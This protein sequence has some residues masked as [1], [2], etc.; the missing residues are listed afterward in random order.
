MNNSLNGSTALLQFRFRTARHKKR[1]QYEDFDKQLLA[2]RRE[3]NILYKQQRN[4]GWIE[5]H[6]PVIR[7]WKRYFVLRDNVA[8]SKQAAFFESILSK[9]NTTQ[10]SHRKDFKV[11]KRK[12]GKKVD[13]AKAQHLLQ[14]E[15]LSFSRMKFT[16]AEKQYFEE[17]TV[18]DNWTSKP[19]KVFA[20]TE[21]GCFVLRVRP[22]IITKTR[23]R[24]EVIESRVQQIRNYLFNNVLRGRLDYL[25]DGHSYSWH[26]EKLKEKNP[27][28]NKSFTVILD[29]YYVK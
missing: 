5:L 15:A 13:V 21:P 17:R 10:Y 14:P 19:Y 6:P 11:K 3:E 1:A 23:A 16:E 12:G 20:F 26:E 18:Q 9:I 7:G 24:D 8:K 2:L 22:N 25:L 29:A 28:K 4:L 27:L